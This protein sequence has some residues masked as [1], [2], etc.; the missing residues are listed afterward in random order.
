M[1]FY[2]ELN[3]Y[4]ELLDC[5]SKDI[6]EISGLSPT[7]ISRYL[8]NKRIPRVK[9][10]Y[11]EKIVESLYIIANKKDIKLSKDSIFKTL[12]NSITFN[13]IDYDDFINNFNTLQTE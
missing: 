1:K 4:M 10:E 3:H 11:F 13:D 12:K 2:E 8:N 6:C 9:S 7:I 5:S